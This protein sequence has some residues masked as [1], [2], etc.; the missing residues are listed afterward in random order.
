M[1]SLH[2][3]DQT[4]AQRLVCWSCNAQYHF[5]CMMSN[6]TQ[7]VRT[8]T[9]QRWQCTHCSQK[10]VGDS[11]DNQMAPVLDKKRPGVHQYQLRILQWNTNSN[12]LE[13][14]LL[15]HLPEATNGDVVCIYR[16]ESAANRQDS[17]TQKLQLCP[18]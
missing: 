17:R 4:G 16:D 11:Q 2:N 18:T 3:L 1:L 8:Q 12:H 5:N 14:P 10:L 13:L 9:T 6:R 7:I 15:E